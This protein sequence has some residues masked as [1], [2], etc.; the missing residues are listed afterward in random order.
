MLFN[1]FNDTRR[2]TVAKTVT[3]TYVAMRTVI[4]VNILFIR[5][6]LIDIS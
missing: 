4:P 6:Q 2:P 5:G 3:I 1:E